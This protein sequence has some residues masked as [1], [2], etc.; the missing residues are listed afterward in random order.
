MPGSLAAWQGSPQ[1]L[2]C[3][4]GCPSM[5]TECSYPPQVLGEQP[6]SLSPEHSACDGVS[7]GDPV[8]V[9]VGDGAVPGSLTLNLVT[10]ACPTPHELCSSGTSDNQSIVRL[11]IRQRSSP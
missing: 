6:V 3:P 5:P 7:V 11:D 4:Q 8:L 2:Q 9:A 1:E 10:H